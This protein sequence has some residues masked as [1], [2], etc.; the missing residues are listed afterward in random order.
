MKNN[1]IVIGGGPAGLIAS[2]YCDGNVTLFDKNKLLARKLR[3]TGKGRCNITN[4]CDISEFISAV[5]T[6]P[7]FLYSAFYS[8]TNNDIISLLNSLGVEIKEERGGRVFPKSDLARD[9]A[10]ALIKYARQKGVKFV[11]KKISGINTSNGC[12]TGVVD[13]E[14][15][16]YPANK[17]ILA[18]GGVSYPL[19]GSTGDGYNIAKR[20]GHTVVPPKPSL[21]PLTVSEGYVSDLEGLSLRNIE[22]NVFGNSKKPVYTDFGEMVFTK[23]G[24]SGPVIL[25]ASA[26]LKDIGNI[27]YKL[28]I[29]LKPALDEAQLDKRVLR[30]F[31]EFKNKNF[32]NALDKLLPKKLIPVIINLSGINPFAKV[33]EITKEQRL[34]LVN[35]I[36]KF[37]F[38]ING[39]GPIE[40][41]IITSGGI[42]VKEINPSTMESK[43]VKGLYFA[44]EVIDVDAYTGGFNL[45]IAYSTGYLAGIN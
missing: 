6:N 39:T 40:E 41:A 38:T 12:V 33:N 27:E 1:V 37:P 42:N 14:G 15:N 24:V 43:L 17:V 18:T 7:N 23:D 3:I 4:S 28:Y 29:D 5:R 44:G 32:S 10:E 35:L 26:N 45:Q 20:L 30:D 9:V 31:E 22:I 11:N 16:I 8:F 25:S 36:K 13:N 19:T 2:A 34:M 21:V